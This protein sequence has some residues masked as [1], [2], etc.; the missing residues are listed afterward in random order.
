MDTFNLI[1]PG[2]KFTRIICSNAKLSRNPG[3]AEGNIFKITAF[4]E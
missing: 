3:N 4:Q 1:L 2:Q